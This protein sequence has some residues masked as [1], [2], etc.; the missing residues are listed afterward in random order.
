MNS[1]SWMIY[2]A[3]VVGTLKDVLTGL[4]VASGFVFS[5]GLLMSGAGGWFIGED[6]DAQAAFHAF[7]KRLWIPILLI[8]ISIVTPSR[9]TIYMIAASE[10]VQ[11]VIVDPEMKTKIKEWLPDGP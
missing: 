6:S 10:S 5:I 1:I 2:A 3:E 9:S 7:M 11:A 8:F 4:A